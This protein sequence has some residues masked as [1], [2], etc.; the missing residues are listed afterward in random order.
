MT[1]MLC[2]SDVVDNYVGWPQ[3]EIV[4]AME[5]RPE[6]TLQKIQCP[7]PPDGGGCACGHDRCI[8]NYG[9]DAMHPNLIIG[10][11]DLISDSLQ[12]VWTICQNRHLT[13]LIYMGVH[14]Q[15]C[16]LGK[17]MGLRNLKAAGMQ[18]ILARD[19][20][21]A[22]PGYDLSCSKYSSMAAKRLPAP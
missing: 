6:P 22:H 17:S 14:T 3:R 21:D 4:L 9:W 18:C 12:E 13:H 16:L 1:V 2:P 5:K 8:P 20:T 10:A 11:D 19:M 15:V 7:A